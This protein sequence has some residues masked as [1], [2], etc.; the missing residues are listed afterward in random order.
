MMHSVYQCP[1]P[2]VFVAFV[3]DGSTVSLQVKLERTRRGDTRKVTAYSM[4]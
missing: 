3:S 4:T 1:S 2:N